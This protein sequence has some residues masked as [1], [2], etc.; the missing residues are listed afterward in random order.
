MDSQR[1]VNGLVAALVLPG[2]IGVLVLFIDADHPVCTIAPQVCK[3]MGAGGRPFH[4][5]ATLLVLFAWWVACTRDK[6]LGDIVGILSWMVVFLFILV[7]GMVIGGIGM[8]VYQF[9][10]MLER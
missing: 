10:W 8:L 4:I 7:N 6:R 5:I 9:R 3:Y 1:L 2:L